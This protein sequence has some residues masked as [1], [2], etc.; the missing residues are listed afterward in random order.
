MKKWKQFEHLV[1]LIY[2]EL[3]PDSKVKIDDKIRGFESGIDRQIDVSIKTRFAGSNILVIVQAKDYNAKADINVV[4]TFASVIKDV[5]ASKGVLICNKGFTSGAKK[6]AK[7]LL[8]DI[9]S[10]H[11]INESNWGID[12]KMPVLVRQI[13]LNIDF[14]ALIHTETES[15]KMDW[16]LIE[17][18]PWKQIYSKDKTTELKSPMHH[19]RNL[20]NNKQIDIVPGGNRLEFV[21]DDNDLLYLKNGTQWLRVKHYDILFDVTEL[22]WAKKLEATEFR[23]LKNHITDELTISKVK[24]SDEKINPSKED[25]WIEVED[26]KNI[27][28]LGEFWLIWNC[29]EIIGENEKFRVDII[30]TK[31]KKADNKL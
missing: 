7:N 12:Y 2:K 1:E 19:F 31:M 21:L 8:I 26:V 29:T 9:F 28:V 11:D 6:L 13:K 27:P 20:W 25:G 24:V 5:R 18:N 4:G 23:A 15:Q 17:S 30:P 14:D 16:D 3:Q 10:A 22:F